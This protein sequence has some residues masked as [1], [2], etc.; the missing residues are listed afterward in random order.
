[1]RFIVA[2]TSES[3]GTPAGSVWPPVVAAGVATLVLAS[4]AVIPSGVRAG[5]SH[6]GVGTGIG[7]AA[8]LRTGAA[9]KPQ[10]TTS[11]KIVAATRRI[12][13]R[14]ALRPS[15]HVATS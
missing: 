7:V 11:P 15:L 6:P 14:V 4:R 13:V 9:V 10:T 3:A 1:M 12:R 8:V 5:T 2:A